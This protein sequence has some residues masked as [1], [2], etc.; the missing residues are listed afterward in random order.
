MAAI[1][2]KFV[3]TIGGIMKKL[4]SAQLFA[5]PKIARKA[6]ARLERAKLQPR[7]SARLT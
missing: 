3:R 1:S 4:T 5:G 7:E 2:G 6:E